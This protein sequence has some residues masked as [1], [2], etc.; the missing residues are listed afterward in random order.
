MLLCAFLHTTWS[1]G[2]GVSSL[3]SVS[4]NTTM[5]R[6]YRQKRIAP[7]ASSVHSHF[8]DGATKE[9]LVA[10]LQTSYLHHSLVVLLC[11]SSA[12]RNRMWELLN[13]ISSLST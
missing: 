6:I 2:K 3:K 10:C 4:T 8:S 12:P 9:T 11:E 7:D 5:L 1:T 13:C